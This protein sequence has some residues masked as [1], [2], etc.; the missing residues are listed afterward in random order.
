M[1]RSDSAVRFAEIRRNRVS[2][3]V[4]AA[5]T[6][7]A[8]ATVLYRKSDSRIGLCLSFAQNR[9][10][11]VFFFRASAP[12]FRETFGDIP[13]NLSYTLALAWPAAPPRDYRI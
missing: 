8:C 2:Q 11:F 9:E 5:D 13:N 3:S 6:Q 7:Y 10:N 12:K 4:A 1:A